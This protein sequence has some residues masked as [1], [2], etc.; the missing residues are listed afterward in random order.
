MAPLLFTFFSPLSPVVTFV[1]L[2]KRHHCRKWSCQTLTCAAAEQQTTK[3]SR[4]T[5][6]VI[7][8][9]TE[10]IFSIRYYY[11][12]IRSTMEKD[13]CGSQWDMM[14]TM[15]IEGEQYMDVEAF[16]YHNELSTIGFI[17][18]SPQVK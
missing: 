11:R 9:F 14:T 2:Y 3:H 18:Q 8:K 5:I 16:Q 17:E 12:S 13:V 7:V 1:C 4:Q 6:P 10:Q 15:L